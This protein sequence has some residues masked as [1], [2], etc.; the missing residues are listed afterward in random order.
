L[1]GQPYVDARLESEITLRHAAL[2]IEPKRAQALGN[3][4]CRLV[5]LEA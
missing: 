3:E 4:A 2:G 1:R 5:L